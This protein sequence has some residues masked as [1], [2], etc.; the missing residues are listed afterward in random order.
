MLAS[1]FAI[2][3][4]Y[5]KSLSNYSLVNKN[6]LFNFLISMMETLD[7]NQKTLFVKNMKINLGMTV[8][9]QFKQYIFTKMSDS[10]LLELFN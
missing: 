8:F 3:G 2:L 1:S 4:G 5:T 7:D 10:P 9:T 6:N